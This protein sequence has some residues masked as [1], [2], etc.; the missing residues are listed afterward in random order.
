MVPDYIFD[1]NMEIFKF[2]RGTAFRKKKLPLFRLENSNFPKFL[3]E[4]LSFK[5]IGIEA[6]VFSLATYV[7]T[8]F[9][10][11]LGAL[12]ITVNPLVRHVNIT[13][14]YAF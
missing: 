6:D 9:S 7:A 1:K 4:M 8:D 2:L 14:D 3:P 11:I 5:C 12:T 13:R 10:L